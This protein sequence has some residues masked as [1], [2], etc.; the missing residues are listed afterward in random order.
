M[1]SKAAPESKAEQ[2]RFSVSMR[3][4]AEAQTLAEGYGRAAF[5]VSEI[6][7]AQFIAGR[8]I[9][10]GDP[11]A[12]RHL[13]EKRLATSLL[14]SVAENTA[15]AVSDL[16]SQLPQAFVTALRMGPVRVSSDEQPSP[17]ESELVDWDL[18]GVQF[19]PSG[20]AESGGAPVH[21]DGYVRTRIGMSLAD[22]PEEVWASA[23]GYWRM[24]PDT[25]YLAPTRFGYAPYVFKTNSWNSAGSRIWATHGSLI[26]TTTGTSHAMLESAG[27]KARWLP[28]VDPRGKPASQQDLAVARLITGRVIGLDRRGPNPVQRLRSRTRRLHSRSDS[29]AAQ[30]S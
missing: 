3:S 22:S 7:E 5:D 17:T 21:P 2:Y 16:E 24:S 29:A 9:R 4:Y 23:R 13:R 1:A 15:W 11:H 27:A 28:S 30:D 20:L 6:A 10:L 8:A 18:I 12:E 19:T 26:D 25:E 14:T